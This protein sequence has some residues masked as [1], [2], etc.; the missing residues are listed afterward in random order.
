MKYSNY[1]NVMLICMCNVVMSMTCFYYI[2][3][4]FTSIPATMPISILF[5]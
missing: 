5:D 4:C 1:V 3:S 2:F